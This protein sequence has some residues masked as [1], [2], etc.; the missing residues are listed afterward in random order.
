M[1]EG[2]GGEGRGGNASLQ[3][4]RFWKKLNWQLIKILITTDYQIWKHLLCSLKHSPRDCK[5]GIKKELYDKTKHT[6]FDWPINC[7]L[8]NTT[9]AAPIRS[10][11]H[12]RTQFFKIV[13]FASKRSLLSPSPPPSFLFFFCARGELARKHL[14]RGLISRRPSH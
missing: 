5:T 12:G 7:Y 11:V 10:C 4:P 13:R 2:R 1:E 14:L 9:S 6:W 8:I 3:T